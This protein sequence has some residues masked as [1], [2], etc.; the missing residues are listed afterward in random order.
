MAFGKTHF[1]LRC[2]GICL[3][4]LLSARCQTESSPQYFSQAIREVPNS[5]GTPSSILAQRHLFRIARSEILTNIPK[6]VEEVITIIANHVKVR[7]SV[8]DKLPYRISRYVDMRSLFVKKLTEE[9]KTRSTVLERELRQLAHAHLSLIELCSRFSEA[10][11][12]IATGSS[13]KEVL[14]L[15]LDILLV[16]LHD[17]DCSKEDGTFMKLLAKCGG[18]NLLVEDEVTAGQRKKLTGALESMT[19]VNAIVNEMKNGSA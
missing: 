16:D 8:D 6:Y 19:K 2:E 13:A 10:A 7:L 1:G 11:L 14:T 4:F 3:Y 17:M 9:L 5:T 15:T 18:V 12:G